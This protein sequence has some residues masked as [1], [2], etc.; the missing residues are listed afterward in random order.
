MTFEEL[1]TI[2]ANGFK[3]VMTEEDFDTFEDM[4]F[5]YQMDANDIKDEVEA[6]INEANE[7]STELICMSDDRTD[8]YINDNYI[9]YKKFSA[10][11]RKALV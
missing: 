6:Y 10:M 7:N 5:C 9:S 2:V 3:E 1:A 11:W 4:R 8:V